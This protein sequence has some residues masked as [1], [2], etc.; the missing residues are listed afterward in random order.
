M[1]KY[2]ETDRAKSTQSEYRPYAVYRE[3]HDTENSMDVVEYFA[4]VPQAEAF[5]RKQ[6]KDPR[7][8]W[9]IGVYE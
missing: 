7:F 5:I 2:Y 6:R 1:S 8:N 9:R 4:T 3:W